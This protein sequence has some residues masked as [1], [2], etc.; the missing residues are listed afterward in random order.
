MALGLLAAPM[1][2]WVPTAVVGEMP[3]REDWQG[4]MLL[5]L[6]GTSWLLLLWEMWWV[7]GCLC[8]CCCQA[9]LQREGPAAARD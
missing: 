1:A 6:V 3:S 5:L 4:W 8:C 2:L 9:D 7:E